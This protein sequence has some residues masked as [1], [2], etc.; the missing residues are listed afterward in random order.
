YG[1]LG[2]GPTWALLGVAGGVLGGIAWLLT[3][4]PR[5]RARVA[6]A[7]LC[8][9]GAGAVGWGVG[10]GRHLAEWERRLGFAGLVAAAAGFVAFAALPGLRRGL[11]GARGGAAQ[12]LAWT[13]AVLVAMAVVEAVNQLVLVRLYPA[14]HAG[15]TALA[16]ALA[17][18][19]GA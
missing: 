1:Y 13:G 9:I 3:E 2:L 10:G 18:F 16:L 19:A 6:F 8:G 7:L 4:S 17:A 5:R 11:A 14:F 15:L 12:R